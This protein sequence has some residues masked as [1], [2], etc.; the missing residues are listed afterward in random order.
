MHKVYLI[1]WF[2]QAIPGQILNLSLRTFGGTVAPVRQSL[3]IAPNSLGL[4]PEFLSGFAID[5]AA[6]ELA[7]PVFAESG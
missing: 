5:D 4:Y 3:R 6:I 2:C 7:L 1:F